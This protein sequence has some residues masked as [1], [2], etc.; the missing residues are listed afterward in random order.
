MDNVSTTAQSDDVNATAAAA[1]L[2][3]RDD[4]LVV[5]IWVVLLIFALVANVICVLGVLRNVSMR[6]V[7][8][9]PYVHHSPTHSSPYR[10][11]PTGS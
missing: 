10:H 11:H 1:E 2:S 6:R 9:P 3:R 7:N 5:G 4:A 8:L